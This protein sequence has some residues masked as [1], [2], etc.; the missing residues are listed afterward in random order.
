MLLSLIVVRANAWNLRQEKPNKKIPTANQL[1]KARVGI[2]RKNGA[3]P[4]IKQERAT[5]SAVSPIRPPNP[6]FSVP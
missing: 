5:R 3:M 4:L 2:H 1:P 6:F